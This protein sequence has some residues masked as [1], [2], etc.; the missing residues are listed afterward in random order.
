M[1]IPPSVFNA[2]GCAS[3][4]AHRFQLTGVL[5]SREADGKPVAVATDG[6]TLVQ[7][8]WTEDDA[9]CFPVYPSNPVDFEA[10]PG[11]TA[12]IPSASCKRLEKMSV[13]AGL[14]GSDQIE[15]IALDEKASVES[16]QAQFSSTDL[17]TVQRLDVKPI[18]ATYP[19]YKVVIDGIDKASP[20]NDRR[21]QTLDITPHILIQALQ[22]M[23]KTSALPKKECRVT[24]NV[25]CEVDKAG[26][27]IPRPLSFT[28]K[29]DKVETKAFVMP[30]VR[31]K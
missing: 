1:L 23:I 21:I 14:N 25:I 7:A 12:I 9:K 3:K 13:S 5:L 11:Y 31:D 8:S 15:N 20:G 2:V 24:L 19:D 6:K 18:D 10:V 26:D 17:D 16:K 4:D 27:S 28:A 30:M 22:T 29:G